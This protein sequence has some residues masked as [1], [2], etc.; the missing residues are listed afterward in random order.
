VFINLD[1]YPEIIAYKDLQR[2]QHLRKEPKWIICLLQEAV[3]SK[4][5]AIDEVYLRIDG[6]KLY[7]GPRLLKPVVQQ[8]QS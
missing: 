7:N 3:T 5:I 1:L 6:S 2:V 4:Q 8:K